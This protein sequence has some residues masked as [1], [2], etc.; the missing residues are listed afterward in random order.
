MASGELFPTDNCSQNHNLLGDADRQ[1]H[2]DYLHAP[3]L[4][5]RAGTNIAAVSISSASHLSS[6]TAIVRSSGGHS[7]LWVLAAGVTES[8][9]YFRFILCMWQTPFAFLTRTIYSFLYYVHVYDD[10]DQTL[11]SWK[12]CIA[13]NA[14]LKCKTHLQCNRVKWQNN[15]QSR[16]PKIRKGYWQNWIG[17]YTY[18]FCSTWH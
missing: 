2:N 1:W 13:F 3:C 8:N 6:V 14:A 12:H 5:P 7:A 9:S 10:T 17:F 15:K 4:L 16:A 11:L 18:Y